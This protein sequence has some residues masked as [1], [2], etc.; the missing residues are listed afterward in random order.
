MRREQKALRHWLSTPGIRLLYRRECLLPCLELQAVIKE[1]GREEIGDATL[2]LLRALRRGVQRQDSLRKL[3]GI[4]RRALT[5]IIQDQIGNSTIERSGDVI[6][7]TPLGAESLRHGAP[8][9]LVHRALRY[10]ALTSELLPRAAYSLEFEV[11]RS[12]EESFL[13]FKDIIPEPE[14]LIDLSGA[15]LNHVVK[16]TDEAIDIERITSY[17][18]AYIRATLCL[19]R[20]PRGD[21]AWMMLG[22]LVKKYP[23]EAVMPLLR[24]FDR[25]ARLG[26]RN[27]GITA[28]QEIERDLRDSSVQL[29]GGI[30][31]DGYGCPVVRIVNAPDKWL[32]TRLGLEDPFVLLCGTRNMEAKPITRFPRRDVLQGNC[33]SIYVENSRLEQEIELL[34]RVF[35]MMDTVYYA[36]P[37]RERPSIQGFLNDRLSPEELDRARLLI[38]RFNIRRATFWLPG[39]SSDSA[40]DGS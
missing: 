18:P 10:C 4:P 3:M 2:F 12:M 9:K 15:Q 39:D 38:T 37:N 36:T 35:D 6:R 32:S 25:S 5:Q 21:T 26:R 24:P 19:T 23:I 27:S 11:F 8:L 14:H 7:I 29:R 33:M 22:D 31:V 34:R 40:S 28:G 30:S 1:R 20:S 16:P 13:E 17:Q